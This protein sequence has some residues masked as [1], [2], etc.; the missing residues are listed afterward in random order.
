MKLIKKIKSF[1]KKRKEKSDLWKA[2]KH[3]I[4]ALA[5]WKDCP[6][7][8]SDL[9]FHLENSNIYVRLGREFYYE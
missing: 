2:K 1:F 5:Y 6:H 7:E 9:V 4:I 3:A 8:T